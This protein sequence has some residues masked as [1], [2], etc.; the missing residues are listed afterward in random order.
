[1]RVEART[2]RADEWVRY[3][4][5]MYPGGPF[6]QIQYLSTNVSG[7]P[8]VTIRFT[9]GDHLSTPADAMWEVDNATA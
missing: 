8:M 7:R 3:V 5:G 2:L 6:R 4:H 1:M 9:N